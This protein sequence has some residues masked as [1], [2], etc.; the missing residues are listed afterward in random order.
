MSADQRKAVL[1]LID[2]VN[3]NLPAIWVVAEFTLRSI[4]ATMKICVAILAFVW[5]V[6]EIKIRVTIHALHYRV[7]SAQRK[8]GLRMCEFRFGPD[9]LPALRGMTL[10]TRN[11]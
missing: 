1:V 2:V 7:A 8:S 5:D 9:W 10:L 3:R 11:L 4:F 6:A